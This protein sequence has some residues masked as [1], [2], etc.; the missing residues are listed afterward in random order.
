MNCPQCK[1]E[2]EKGKNFCTKC[3]Y[4]FKKG[5]R[6]EVKILIAVFLIASSLILIPWLIGVVSIIANM[7]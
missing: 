5:I 3:G 4:K 6:K 7:K 1:S 2:I